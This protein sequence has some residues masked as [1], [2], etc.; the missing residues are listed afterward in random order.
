FE[1]AEDIRDWGRDLGGRAV[2]YCKGAYETEIQ[3]T[4]ERANYGW[5]YSIQMQWD[6]KTV[7]GYVRRRLAIRSES[8]APARGDQHLRRQH[9]HQLHVRRR[10]ATSHRVEAST[11]LLRPHVLVAFSAA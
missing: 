7:F 1:S 10:P 8:R 4:G 6:R 5:D 3:F 2:H 11:R 9:Q